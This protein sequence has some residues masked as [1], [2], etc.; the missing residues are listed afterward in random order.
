MPAPPLESPGKNDYWKSFER[1]KNH[2]IRATAHLPITRR[3]RPLQSNNRNIIVRDLPTGPHGSSGVFLRAVHL[4]LHAFRAPRRWRHSS[5]TPH[6][7]SRISPCYHAIEGLSRPTLYGKEAM[8]TR[9]TDGKML[10]N[11]LYHSAVVSG[12]PAG[13][14]RLGKIATGGSPQKLDFTHRDVDMV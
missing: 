2:F 7:K 10:V 13:Y 12:L 9:V 8:T 5:L 4:R 1:P 3:C 6:P 11:A 14:A